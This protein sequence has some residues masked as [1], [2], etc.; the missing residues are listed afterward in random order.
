MSAFTIFPTLQAAISKDLIITT[1]LHYNAPIKREKHPQS[2]P[3]PT[4]IAES[5]IIYMCTE[6]SMKMTWDRGGREGRHMVFF[7]S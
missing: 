5:N 1:G 6:L 2:N 4:H 3:H 7:I